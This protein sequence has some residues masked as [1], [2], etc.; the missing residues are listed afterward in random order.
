MGQQPQPLDRFDDAFLVEADVV[1]KTGSMRGYLAIAIIRVWPPPGHSTRRLFTVRT[2]SSDISYKFDIALSGDCFNLPDGLSLEV[3]DALFLDLKGATLSRTGASSA[4]G[5]LPMRMSYTISLSL[6]LLS[7]RIGELPRR[8]DLGKIDH[9]KFDDS[10]RGNSVTSA[11]DTDTVMADLTIDRSPSPD[12]ASSSLYCGPAR[13]DIGRPDRTS[14]F[15]RDFSAK[16]QNRRIAEEP[17]EPDDDMELAYSCPRFSSPDVPEEL[18]MNKFTP[19]YYLKADD[20]T[21]QSVIGVVASV[22]RRGFSRDFYQSLMLSD[23]SKQMFG[24]TCFA[25]EEALLPTCKRGDVLILRGITTGY[26]AEGTDPRGKA[27][28][29]GCLWKV[30]NPLFAARYAADQELFTPDELRQCYEI[31]QWWESITSTV[32]DSQWKGRPRGLICDI[33]AGAYYDFV[34]EVVKSHHNVNSDVWSVWVTDYTLNPD[35]IMPSYRFYPAN[36]YKSKS[37]LRIEMWD[38][39]CV[40][41]QSMQ[42]GELYSIE[43]CLIRH[44]NHGRIEGKLAS[45]RGSKVTKLDSRSWAPAEELLRRKREWQTN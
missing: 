18:Q 39:Q 4:P 21:L 23:P 32:V 41:G 11:D 38:G 6:L 8:F 10:T 43:N 28:K 2:T 40:T 35:P 3:N 22:G 17:S 19:L 9:H 5:A 26:L 14:S 25:S 30:F 33:E 13:V 27:K 36:M 12:S 16:V 15:G 34:V 24:L 44:D 31:S 29:N 42:A 7:R 37:V 45:I 20:R 1:C